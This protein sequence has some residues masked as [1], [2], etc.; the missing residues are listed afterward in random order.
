MNIPLGLVEDIE[1][2]ED[3]SCMVQLDSRI[4]WEPAVHIVK[5]GAS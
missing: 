5:K 1:I 4:G 3:R 2:G